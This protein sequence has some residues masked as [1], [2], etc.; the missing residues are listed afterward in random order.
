VN[1][2]ALW[3]KQQSRNSCLVK[4]FLREAERESSKKFSSSIE[5]QIAPKGERPPIDS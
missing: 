3:L 5:V 2:L 1:P 4:N